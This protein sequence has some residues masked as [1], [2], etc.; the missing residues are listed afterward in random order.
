MRA[1]LVPLLLVWGQACFEDKPPGDTAGDLPS[2]CEDRDGDGH[3]NDPCGLDCDDDNPSVSPDVQEICDSIDDDC[4]GLVDDDDP[5]ID[6]STYF[7]WYTDAD[8]DGY[9]TDATAS[10][11]CDPPS[12]DSLLEGGD[13]DDADPD[14]HPGALEVCDDVD[15]D[16]D[17]DADRSCP[18]PLCGD[19]SSDTTWGGE[20]GGYVVTCD[21][22]V[23]ANLTVAPGTTVY[24]APDVGL[25]VGA[26]PVGGALIIDAADDPVTFTSARAAEDSGEVAAPGDWRGVTLDTFAD[27]SATIRGLQLRYGGRDDG[28]AGLILRAETL[29]LSDSQICDNLGA[30]VAVQAGATLTLEDST[31]CDNSGDGLAAL[32]AALIVRGSVLQGNGGVGLSVA[33]EGATGAVIE[34]TELSDNG[35]SGLT[36][37]PAD[38]LTVFTGNTV[39]GNGAFPIE[40]DVSDVSALDSSSTFSGNTDDRIR[41]AGDELDEDS[42]W[43][44]LDADYL[45]TE[46]ISVCDST[47]TPLLTIVGGSTVYFD[48]DTALVIGEI[49]EGALVVSGTAAAPVTFTSEMR[50]GGVWRGL[51]FKSKCF[52]SSLDYLTIEYGSYNGYFDCANVTVSDST[53]QLSG[54]TD[55]T[56][57]A[58]RG[59]RAVFTSSTAT[60]N[61]GCTG[62]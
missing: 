4:D 1:R 17:G 34:D 19:V 61:D 39:T 30:G 28:G 11:S 33:G 54:D 40:L 27:T 26:G 25:L 35:A 53:F 6:T 48:P 49:S 57:T 55:V 13:C 21:I 23:T 7:D 38:A 44:D 52:A 32:D 2:T 37:T 16:C 51:S 47:H 60:S 58:S 15:S 31:V 18:T 43:A 56:C 20:P 62:I 14:I 9:G 12:P 42:T 8:G 10:S 59:S 36:I 50:T 29:T 41:I 3:N 46:R 22:S 24:F 45:V 5:S